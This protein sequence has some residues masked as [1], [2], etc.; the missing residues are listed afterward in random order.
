MVRF[1]IQ[2]R[3][4]RLELEEGAPRALRAF[5]REGASVFDGRGHAYLLPIESAGRLRKLMQRR[6]AIPPSVVAERGA[7]RF[8][9]PPEISLYSHQP[10]GVQF[11]MDRRSA[12][13]ADDMGLGKTLQAILAA[14]AV[15]SGRVL[16]VCPAGLIGN[17]LAELR[18]WAPDVIARIQTTQSF[19]LDCDYAIVS[20]DS[21]KMVGPL[22]RA[23]LSVDWSVLIVDEAHRAKNPRSQRHAFLAEVKTERRW[24][25][26]GMP[27]LNRP[28]DVLGLLRV[29]EHPLGSS[30]RNFNRRF[31][32][33]DEYAETASMALGLELAG[34]IMRRYKSDVLDLPAKTKQ[35]VTVHTSAYP[36]TSIQE[37][38]R[39]RRMLAEEKSAATAD[40]VLDLLEL[41]DR[42]V[43]VFSCFKKPLD[44]VEATLKRANVAT[45]R[46]DGS[47]TGSRRQRVVDGF[48][49][50]DQRVLLG[51]IV[52]AGE[53]IN[54]THATHVLFNDLSYVPAEHAQAEDR[55]Y[56]IGQDSEVVAY[57]MLSECDLDRAMWDLTQVKLRNIGSFEDGLRSRAEQKITPTELFEAMR[58]RRASTVSN[59]ITIKEA[60]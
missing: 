45:C 35:V 40:R 60:S 5:A 39:N 30:T 16:I 56:R 23:L 7:G 19:D 58:R 49:R 9:A 24:Q 25:L 14:E 3:F 37:L 36:T 57:Y 38:T 1:E 43:I 46:I 52:A 28:G 10:A 2:D 21:A 13:L 47:V 6:D 44:D 51:Q 29:G 8:K 34:W 54:L 11:L 59:M 22:R 50:G 17:W 33:D 42:G 48:Q 32:V 41:T 27:M 31:V 20:Y 12:F 18:K 4:I 26:S 53:G 15:R 55:C